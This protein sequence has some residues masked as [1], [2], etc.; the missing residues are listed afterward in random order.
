MK[1]LDDAACAIGYFVSKT[2]VHLE[3]GKELWVKRWKEKKKKRIGQ[4]RREECSGES[5]RRWQYTSRDRRR[6]ET[7]RTDEER[8]DQVRTIGVGNIR[9]EKEEEDKRR[10]QTK[11]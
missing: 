2:S 11:R 10:E 4:R 5:H 1:L 3:V 9:R 8:K 6:R 7:E